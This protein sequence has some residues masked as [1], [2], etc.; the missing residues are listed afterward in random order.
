VNKTKIQIAVLV[1]GAALVG[2]ATALWFV[3]AEPGSA[4]GS[5]TGDEREIL[6]WAAPM[7]P[8]YRRDE[9]G[10]SPMGMDLIP[11]YADEGGASGSDQPS[12]R[13]NP[14]VINNIGIKTAP[15]KRGTLYRNIETVGF[16]TPDADRFE[17]IH[18]RVEGWI[19]ELVADTEG[20]RVK[21]G[22]LLF[23][24]YSPALVSAQDEYLQAMR[25]G[26]S[27]LMRATATRLR[28]LGM[29]DDQIE[30]LK[31]RGEASEL[32][33]VHAPI[34]GYV[35]DLGV[36]QGMFV[37][38]GTTIMSLA[39][40]STVWVD[41]DVFEN[42][43]DW[44][45]TGQTARMKLP[46]APE[47]EWTGEVDYVY[48]TIRAETRTARVRLAFDNPDLVLK[49]NMYANV[50]IDGA[51]RSDIVHVPSQA[52]IRTGGQ[53]RLILA[54]GD[55]HFRP[56][57]VR[58]GLES[59]GR[60]EILGGLAE[61]EDIVVSSQFLI[62]SEASMDASLLRMI[63]DGPLPGQD[64][65][66]HDMEG[67]DHS[68]HDMKQDASTPTAPREQGG[69]QNGMEGMDHSGHDMGAMNQSTPEME[70]M[71]H[72]APSQP[73]PREQERDQGQMDHS[74]HDMEGMDHDGDAS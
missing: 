41:V 69:K 21:A 60:V 51:P 28:A 35:I 25:S 53:E 36:R 1:M 72:D 27:A 61:G 2:A 67:M 19:E 30:A 48:P 46:F 55:G 62:D 32:F 23:R 63:G 58:T 22:E 66:G 65:A 33:D 11:V 47:R 56:A 39:D 31:S 70:G 44:V 71:D 59:E 74:A 26:Q 13:I 18:V 14:T 42:Q 10:K 3:G 37:Q 7:D 38:P 12:I 15:A 45:E 16:I 5:A 4:G 43:I 6:Y 40:L 29:Q 57:L 50:A 68:E 17:H 73:L 24:I 52:V 49:P 9:P 34:N 64:H 8:N 54:L 20:D